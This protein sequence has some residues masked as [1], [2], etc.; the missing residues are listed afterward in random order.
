[1]GCLMNPVVILAG[2]VLNPVVIQP[3]PIYLLLS[4]ILIGMNPAD[5]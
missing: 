5:T 1:M 3:R 4:L 2:H